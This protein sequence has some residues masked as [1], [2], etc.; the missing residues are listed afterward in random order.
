MRSLSPGLRHRSGFTLVELL[1]VIAIIGILV[2]LLL[3]AVQMAR[4]AARRTACTNNLK[5]I[6]LAAHNYHDT[7]GRL[8]LTIGW[9][10][11][12]GACGAEPGAFSDK[13]MLLPYIEQGPLYD[14]TSF[15]DQTS[16]PYAVTWCGGG[17]LRLS[18]RLPVYNCPSNPFTVNAGRGNFTY[19]TNM[20]TSHFRHTVNS[21]RAD[22]GKHNGFGVVHGPYYDQTSFDPPLTF[23]NF[24]DGLSNTAAYA[25]F[26]IDPGPDRDPKRTVYTWVGGNN[27][28]EVRQNCLN[29]TNHSGRSFI[30]TGAIGRGASWSWGFVNMGPFYSHT[31][32]PNERSCFS[33]DGAHWGDWAGTNLMAAN[34]G[35]PAG[36][37]VARGD[38]SVSFVNNNINEFTWWALGTRDGGEAVT[39]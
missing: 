22:A 17:D 29:Q 19:A 35:H 28:A 25:E 38:G 13:F 31:M 10:S 32:K 39:Q 4:E 6:A 21:Q 37:N 18:V 24:P 23:G 15:R 8:P 9:G 2:A 3:P 33:L 36:V 1:V 7:I 20:G 27:T 14:G 34:S 12:G 26:V 30:Q 5:Q 11:E 16:L